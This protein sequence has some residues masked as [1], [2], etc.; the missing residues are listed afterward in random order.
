[1]AIELP[2]LPYE[3]NALEPHLTAETLDFHHGKHHNAYVVN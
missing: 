2:P 3:K 1:M